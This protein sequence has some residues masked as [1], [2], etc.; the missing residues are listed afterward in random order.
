MPLQGC[1]TLREYTPRYSSRIRAARMTLPMRA[2]SERMVSVS[3][4]GLE[5]T[6]SVLA[7]NSLSRMSPRFRWL[8]IS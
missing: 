7:A 3:S 6:M 5:P 2:I 4:S 8:T 1:G